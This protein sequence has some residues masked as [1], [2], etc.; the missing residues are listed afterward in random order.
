MEYFSS[1]STRASRRIISGEFT[2]E[3]IYPRISWEQ[4]Q[5]EAEERKGGVGTVCKID[6]KNREKSRI[7][8][9]GD[10]SLRA[11]SPRSFLQF[12]RVTRNALQTVRAE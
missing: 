6:W 1:T 2:F 7:V 3:C 9:S 4:G 5:N 8:I 12:T 11:L 10:F